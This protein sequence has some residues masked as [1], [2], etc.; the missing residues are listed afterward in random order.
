MAPAYQLSSAVSL[1]TCG[2]GGSPQNTQIW[3]WRARL[4]SVRLSQ[5]KSQTVRQADQ[6]GGQIMS[7]LS[8]LI[9]GLRFA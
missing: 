6:E 2:V 3:R 1:P 5:L 9:R 8:G 7:S 4:R